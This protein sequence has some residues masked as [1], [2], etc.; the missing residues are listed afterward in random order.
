MWQLSD[1][2]DEGHTFKK[3]YVTHALPF[4]FPSLSPELTSKG[5]SQEA[6]VRMTAVL[7]LVNGKSH[8]LNYSQRHSYL[9]QMR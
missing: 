7:C 4:F 9:W 5:E 3:I 1:L 6:D 8:R 2:L